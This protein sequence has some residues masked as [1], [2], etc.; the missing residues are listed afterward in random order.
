MDAYRDFCDYRDRMAP[1][2]SIKARTTDVTRESWLA[3]RRKEL[4]SRMRRRRKKMGD[5]SGSKPL[6]LL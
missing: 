6:K 4:Q 1:R 5:R 3:E 2:T